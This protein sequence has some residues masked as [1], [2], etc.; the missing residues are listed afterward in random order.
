MLIRWFA[1]DSG[2]SSPVF[3]PFRSMLGKGV[4]NSNFEGGYETEKLRPLF[5]QVIRLAVSKKHPQISPSL[6]W[7]GRQHLAFLE[8]DTG[9]LLSTS[10][11]SVVLWVLKQEEETNHLESDLLPSSGHSRSLD[12]IFLLHM[13]ANGSLMLLV[14]RSLIKT[15]PT[16]SRVMLGAPSI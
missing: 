9:N 8:Q 3:A 11:V 1:N 4:K 2:H 10:T 12:P 7:P 15:N 13:R 5:S 14:C 6:K 16:F